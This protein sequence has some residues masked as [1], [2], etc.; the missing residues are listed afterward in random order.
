MRLCP[1]H[2]L[3]P[4]PKMGYAKGAQVIALLLPKESQEILKH[5]GVPA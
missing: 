3:R 1:F 4:L 5:V 2:P